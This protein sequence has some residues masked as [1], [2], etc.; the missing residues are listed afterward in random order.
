MKNVE[1]KYNPYLIETFITIDG[2]R[3]KLNSSLNVGRKRLQEWV[4]R[5]PMILLEEYRD[6]NLKVS[7]QGSFSDYEDVRVSFEVF[8]EKVSAELTFTK[9][10]DITDVEN[11]ID[12]IF[13]EI[14]NG[15][16]PELRDESIINAFEKAKDS[17]FEVNVIATMS[18]GKSTL[19]NALLGQQ[20]MPAANEATTATIVKIVDTPREGFSAKAYDKSGHLVSNI[21]HVSIED[22]KRINSD[23]EIPLVELYGRI[24]FVESVGMKLVLVDTP[25]PNNARNTLHQEMTYRM[26]ADSEKSLVLFV[27]NGEQ[28]GINDEKILL[29][30]VCKCMKDGG[31]QGRERFIFAV[32]RMDVFK[33]KD[34]G[35]DCIQRALSN[36][37]DLLEKRGIYSP[38]IFP[39]S[40]LA[41]FELRTNDDEPRA[42]D[43]FRRGV[44]KYELFHFEDYYNFSNLP[45]TVKQRIDSI[46]LSASEDELVEIHTGVI[47]IEQAVS[48]YINKYARTTKV[49]DLVLSFNE[50]LNEL[51]TVAHLEKEILADKETKSLLDKQIDR[52]KKRIASAENA[53]KRSNRIHD[54]DLT[55]IVENKIKAHVEGILKQLNLMM[56]GRSNKVGWE[57]ARTQCE[58]MFSECHAI[59]IQMK[60]DIEKMITDS[61]KESI[62]VILEDYKHCLDD[63]DLKINENAYS[64]KPIKLVS[65]SLADLSKIVDINTISVDEGYMRRAKTKE[66]PSQRKW[67]NPFTWFKEGAHVEILEPEKWINKFVYYVNMEEVA[68]DFIVPLQKNIIENKRRALDFVKT[69]TE[70]L[71]EYLQAELVRIDQVLDQ[72]LTQ[73]SNVKA[74]TDAKQDE[75]IQKE[76]NLKWLEGIQKRVNDIIAF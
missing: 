48:L 42:L 54:I 19:I 46:K 3:P 62:S 5:L 24:P 9:T 69:E 7:F 44:K 1:I 52:V 47:S 49:H 20:L 10:T 15:P 45:Q 13:E 63:L 28:L 50:K 61:Y 74:K 60:V 17:R 12:A 73:L 43:T 67:Y 27:M 55:S 4:D 14:K 38:N 6:P 40:S 2:Q 70:R 21:D 34:E 33:P 11:T 31:K 32:N 39:L 8:Q 51:E 29:D 64:F 22:M 23:P 56:S 58:N 25:G 26:L 76:Q 68:S 36:V 30:Y 41:A 65:A 57:V 18:S 16:I 66:V 35:I 53:Q 37:K 72:K 59:S 71:K 75:I